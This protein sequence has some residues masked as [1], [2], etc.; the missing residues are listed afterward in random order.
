MVILSFS[1]SLFWNDKIVDA[2]CVIFVK[3]LYF[4]PVFVTNCLLLLL[5]LSFLSP[6][7]GREFVPKDLLSCSSGDQ[8]GVCKDSLYDNDE[9]LANEITA[10]ETFSYFLKDDSLLI[11]ARVSPNTITKFSKPFLCCEIQGYLDP[12][13]HGLYAARFR[14]KKMKYAN[15]DMRILNV[16]GLKTIL[17]ING[18]PEYIM[19][20]RGVDMGAAVGGH[21]IATTTSY[22]IN[23]VLGPH[24]VTVIT[25]S[26]C[27]VSLEHCTMVYL[28]DG[29][30]LNQLV[31]NA[32]S[33]G[34]R[35][36][37]FVFIGIH[38]ATIDDFRMEELLYGFDQSKFDDFM[39]FI[40]LRL[41]PEVEHTKP[42][43]RIAAGFS[44]GGAWALDAF[45]LHQDFFSGAISMSPGQWEYHGDVK[46]NGGKVFIGA[47][48]LESRFLKSARRYARDLEGAG[49]KVSETYVP[50]GHG[51]NTW[52]NIW[53]SALKS[54][55]EKQ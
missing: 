28:V 21:T 41:S 33:R 49:A 23:S 19:E 22:F 53:M 1:D 3:D 47:G 37:N 36:D 9:K 4:M 30:S 55:A 52:L 38:N 34:L 7:Y 45:S 54:L 16:D 50:S 18:S 15:V 26:S 13:G 2:T 48:E 32:I 42:E 27:Q 43:R 40:I 8:T 44:N 35:A 46:M 39:N 25:G 5:G 29:E 31:Q 20:E 12:V 51:M 10:N 6:V 14:W 24:D 17:R 11:S